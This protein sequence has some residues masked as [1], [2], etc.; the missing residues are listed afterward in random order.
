[1]DVF[2]NKFLSFKNLIFVKLLM[3]AIVVSF[4]SSALLDESSFKIF[5]NKTNK[6]TPPHTAKVKMIDS[7]AV[8]AI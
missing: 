3:I 5:V 2:V 4:S 6:C 7:K 1:M 8:K